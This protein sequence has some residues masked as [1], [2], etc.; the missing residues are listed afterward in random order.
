MG[1]LVQSWFLWLK[2]AAMVT[3][4]PYPMRLYMAAAAGTPARKGGKLFD[5]FSFSER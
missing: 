1:A 2:A 3:R 5:W 4:E